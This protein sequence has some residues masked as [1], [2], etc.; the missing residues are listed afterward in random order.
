MIFFEDENFLSDSNAWYQS[1]YWDTFM[2]N[3]YNK[4]F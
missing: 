3:E 1:M 2:N 4:I